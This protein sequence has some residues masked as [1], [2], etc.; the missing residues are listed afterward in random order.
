MGSGINAA[1]TMG[2]LR[3]ATRTLAELDLDPAQVMQHLDHITTGLDEAMATCIYAVHDPHPLPPGHRRP[4]SSGPRTPSRQ[5][6]SDRPADRGT[7]RRRRRPVP[8]QRRRP[9]HR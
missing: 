4:P 7:A 3:T 1:A 5:P 2:Q 8:G 9:R 6:P